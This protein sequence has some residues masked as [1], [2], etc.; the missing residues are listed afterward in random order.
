[1][2]D[3]TPE[4]AA[5]KILEYESRIKALEE[6]DREA[7][8]R[9]ARSVQDAGLKDNRLAKY[10][11][12][13]LAE[14]ATGPAKRQFAEKILIK[15]LNVG[16]D[17][18]PTGDT[19]ERADARPT[20]WVPGYIDDTKATDPTQI[21]IQDHL[22]VRAMLRSV[23]AARGVREDEI[24]TPL[25][26]AKIRLLMEGAPEIV[27]KAFID[28][29]GVGGEWMPTNTIAGLERAAELLYQRSLAGFF[30]TVDV[31]RNVTV[32]LMVT[33]AVPY[34]HGVTGDDASRYASS[35]VG[36][37]SMTTALKTLA[38][39]VQAGEDDLEESIV[40]NSPQILLDGLAY[41]LMSAIE[42]AII[43]GD[44]TSTHADTGIAT[45]NPNSIYYAAPGGGATDHRRAW[46]GL[47]HHAGDVSNTVDRSTYTYALTLADIA[48]VVGPPEGIVGVF[49]HRG[50]A[51]NVA[52]LSQFATR[53]VFAQATNT[54]GSTG[55]LEAM[56]IK[57]HRSRLMTDD[58][59][60]S[61]VYDAS[62][63]SY[64]GAVFV[65]AMLWRIF[66]RYGIRAQAVRTDPNGVI[67]L[68]AKTRMDFKPIR[69]TELSTRYQ[70]KLGR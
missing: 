48:T 51:Y 59:N 36:T 2:P 9:H 67:N 70:Y 7:M 34:I 1:M 4:T 40:T 19:W 60:A 8:E 27:R 23:Q 54:S 65:N 57:I 68:V 56:G 24:A 35:N 18:S 64:T 33:A 50:F 46:I 16:Y 66:R 25:L 62:T 11:L 5:A 10:A 55:V 39:R 22:G 52:G 21:A 20:L 31:E 30:P 32:P 49:S 45:W 15:G 38:V 6:K 3:L 44:T 14:K 58:L 69:S 43:N 37:S 53:D 63:T 47:R 61:G 13:S 42:D 41:S 12:P 28:S 26:D 17:G 29:S